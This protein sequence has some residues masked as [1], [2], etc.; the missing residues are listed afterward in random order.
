MDNKNIKIN[1]E[2]K[3]KKFIIRENHK[4]CPEC[5]FIIENKYKHAFENEWCPSCGYGI[6]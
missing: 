6:K 3:K 2:I 1:K 4:I 5:G